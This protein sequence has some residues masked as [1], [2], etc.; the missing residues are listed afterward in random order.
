VIDSPPVQRL[1]LVRQLGVVHWVYPGATHS[2]FEH[3]L[4]VLHQTQQLVNA[5]NQASGAGPGAAPIDN[6]MSALVRLCAILHDI[7]HGV[8]SHVSEHALA[9]RIDL[10]L[11]LQ[12]F[13]RRIGVSKIQLSE[14]IAYYLIGAPAFSAML[15]TAFDRLGNPFSLGGGSA[16][17]AGR[18]AE[19]ARNAIVAHH[20]NEQVPLLHELITGPFD[21]DKL[22]Y[23]QRDAR[24]AGIP[25]L[26][27][28]SRLLQKITTR[29]VASRDMPEDILC[30]MREQHDTRDLFGLKWSG[31]TILDELYLARILLYAKIYRHKKVL[32]IE[33]M[34]DALFVALGSDPKVELIRLIEICYHFCDDQF[35]VSKPDELLNAVGAE[36]ASGGLRAFVDDVLARLRDRNLYVASLALMQKYP[37][38]P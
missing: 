2:R 11:A 28:I 5:I 21:A 9:K 35:L 15:A 23:Y 4:G 25:S 6:A 1:R 32:A 13:A 29:R 24:H 34:I 38:D 17:S 18:V 12:L 14:L 3:S 22:D 33:A 7:G 30:A 10:K 16:E 31:A 37:A 36:E 19:L 8:F 27:D 26:L 20:I